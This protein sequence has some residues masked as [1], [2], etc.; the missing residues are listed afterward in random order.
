M[1]A[2][3]HDLAATLEPSLGC[4]QNEVTERI[5]RAGRKLIAGVS[6]LHAAGS[7]VERE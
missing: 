7:A 2:N 1:R 6:H 3:L 5:A 4:V